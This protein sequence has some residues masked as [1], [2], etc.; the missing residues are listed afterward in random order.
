ML[1]G[2]LRESL[3]IPPF[4]SHTAVKMSEMVRRAAL[5]DAFEFNCR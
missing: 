1:S 2:S 3:L 4:P 5:V